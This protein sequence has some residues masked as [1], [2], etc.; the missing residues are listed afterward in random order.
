MPK[1]PHP[2]SRRTEKSDE[3]GETKVKGFAIHRWNIEPQH[4]QHAKTQLSRPKHNLST[5]VTMTTKSHK[6]AGVMNRAEHACAY[7]F[8]DAKAG[9]NN[10]AVLL[11]ALDTVWSCGTSS[12][13]GSIGF[14]GEVNTHP[15]RCQTE[16][17]D[18]GEGFAIPLKHRSITHPHTTRAR[19]R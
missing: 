16:K 19:A 17:S 15:L 14:F 2:S 12:R 13:L 18:E 11:A 1:R 8:T 3:E 9:P 4:H 6:N 7:P 5:L 10:N